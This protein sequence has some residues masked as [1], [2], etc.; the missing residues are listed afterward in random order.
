MNVDSSNISDDELLN[1]YLSRVIMAINDYSEEQLFTALR[2][3][4]SAGDKTGAQRIAG[5]IQQRRSTQNQD[6]NPDY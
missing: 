1:K 3:A 6:S 4:D 5:L 2:N